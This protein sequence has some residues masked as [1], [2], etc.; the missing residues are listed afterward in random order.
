MGNFGLKIRINLRENSIELYQ[1]V[2]RRS[3][4][5]I[6]RILWQESEIGR[7]GGAINKTGEFISSSKS[8]DAEFSSCELGDCYGS[9]ILFCIIGV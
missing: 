4:C 5:G 3:N 7:K 2:R 6:E 8:F 1:V 9:A